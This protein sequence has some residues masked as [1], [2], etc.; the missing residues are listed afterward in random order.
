MSKATDKQVVERKIPV[1]VYGTLRKG[2]Y[3]HRLLKNAQ[4]MDTGVTVDAYTMYAHSYP[5]VSRKAQDTSIVG[6]FYLVSKDEFAE[7]DRLEGY[8]NYYDRESVKIK[9]SSAW[10]FT[11]SSNVE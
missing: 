10:L 4:F 11:A 5:L 3:N 2:Y 8:P 9:T 1:F 6:E 7:L